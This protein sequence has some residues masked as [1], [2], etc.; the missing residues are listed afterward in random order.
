[1]NERSYSKTNI[2]FE[3]RTIENLRRRIKEKLHCSHVRYYSHVWYCLRYC[4]WHC[5]HIRIDVVA[6]T[7]KV[8][9]Y[10]LTKILM[11]CLSVMWQHVSGPKITR[12]VHAYTQDYFQPNC[13]TVQ[14]A[15]LFKLCHYSNHVVKPCHCS[16]RVVKLRTVDWWHGAILTVQNIFDPMAIIYL[17]Y[18]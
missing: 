15:S 5:S 4:S 11:Y 2:T 16:N 1:M 8:S 10:C 9:R 12:T 3:F 7:D 17:M 18:L 13:I 6:L 14:T